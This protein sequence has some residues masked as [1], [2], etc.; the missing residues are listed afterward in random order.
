MRHVH[1]RASAIVANSHNTARELRAFGVPS[2]AIVVIHPAVDAARFELPAVDRN[3][4]RRL[5]ADDEL[6]LLTV[7]RLQR[8]KG[9]DLVLRALAQLALDRPRV[10]YAIVGEG[11]E[12]G[13][14]ERLA[15]E[16]QLGDLVTFVGEVSPEDLPGYYAAGDIFA[17]PNRVDGVDVEGFG[18]VF[19]EAAAAGLPTIGGATGGVPEAIVDGETG[20][21][22]SGTD[23]AELA[24]TI[25]RL[26]NSLDLRRC[27]GNA[28]QMRV[29]RQFTW[30][31][32][33]ARLAA[34]HEQLSGGA[35]VR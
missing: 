25:R 4:R 17:H 28:G 23:V 32:A 22:V 11:D 7:G 16:L 13:A 26:S 20:F 9:H 29:R 1:R 15:G 35:A 12:R 8:R 5:A 31:Q 30:E 18:M 33:T 27:L 21:L 10:R 3:L 2:E 14:L 34:V 24:T 19:L 6:L